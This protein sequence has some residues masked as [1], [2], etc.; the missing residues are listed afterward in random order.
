MNKL[1]ILNSLLSWYYRKSNVIKKGCQEASKF[2]QWLSMAGDLFFD[3]EGVCRSI[4]SGEWIKF[5]KSGQKDTDRLR[6]ERTGSGICSSLSS[7]SHDYHEME[8]HR[9]PF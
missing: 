6:G 1:D 5:D 9:K 8:I 2:H 3:C 4:F 7:F